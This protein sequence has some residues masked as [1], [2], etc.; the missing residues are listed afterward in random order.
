VER[1]RTFMLTTPTVESKNN[2]RPLRYTNG[3]V[4]FDRVCFSYD[5]KIPIFSKLDFAVPGGA[6]VAFVG[7]T[8]TGK[9]TILQ[10]LC[11][12]YD[13]TG[14]AIRI[15]GQDIRDLDLIRYFIPM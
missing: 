6:T 12:F 7:M 8:G 10:L 13:V 4:V 3:T 2:A 1:L 15:D 11:R 5:K 14:G 9:S